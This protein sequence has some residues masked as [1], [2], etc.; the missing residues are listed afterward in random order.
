MNC[1]EAFEK[2]YGKVGDFYDADAYLT[3]FGFYASGW[4]AAEKERENLIPLFSIIDYGD[5]AKIEPMIP[6]TIESE[7]DTLRD[8]GWDWTLSKGWDSSYF[9]TLLHRDWV[10]QD[11]S[12]SSS[13]IM[14]V[15]TTLKECVAQ[16]KKK[17]RHDKMEY[18]DG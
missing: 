12:M 11:T 5:R 3:R 2:E 18:T 15:G 6:T 8:Q 16:A 10:T 17:I 1:R 9:L 7:L 4:V 14:A 13:C